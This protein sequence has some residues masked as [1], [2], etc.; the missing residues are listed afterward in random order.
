[1]A[2]KQTKYI[3]YYRSKYLHV[4]WALLTQITNQE[5]RDSHYIFT[6]GVLHTDASYFIQ[7]LQ[8]SHNN[9]VTSYHRLGL[10]L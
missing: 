5:S 4:S 2:R 6:T 7:L 8:H 1:M 9:S 10:T 3:K